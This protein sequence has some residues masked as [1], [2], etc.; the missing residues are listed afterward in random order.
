MNGK[1]S[2]RNTQYMIWNFQGYNIMAE[3][4]LKHI[5]DKLNAGF[6]VIMDVAFAN[7]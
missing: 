4:N 3:L 2:I 6:E 1:K 7:D 5:V